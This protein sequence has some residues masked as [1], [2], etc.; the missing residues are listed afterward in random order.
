M[1]ARLTFLPA[2]VLLACALPMPAQSAPVASNAPFA[3]TWFGSF[4]VKSPD[5]VLHHDAAVLVLT[6]K[7][8]SLS[9]A[10]GSK[11][12]QMSPVSGIRISGDTIQFH[13]DAA[14]GLDFTLRLKDGHLT[15]SSSGKMQAAVDVRPAPGL[16]PH[17]Q[18]VAEITEA[19]RK[20]FAAFDACDV[21]G[22]ASF[23]APDL[24]F[25]RDQGGESGYQHQLDALQQ[26]CAE[27][28]KGHRE[29][30]PGSLIINVAPGTGAIEAGTQRFYVKQQDGTERIDATARFTE[31]WSKESG[32]WKLVRAISYD[33][34]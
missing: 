32:S 8:G 10:I 33:H 29:L 6:E 13:M 16:E 28:I 21:Q 23:L 2:L 12:D 24:E 11:I 7:D 27:G 5:G 18:L 22:Y 4:D 14:G 3:G 25:Y 15:G 26:R 30:V 34:E 9:G 20:L 31:I 1:F 17:D 19:D